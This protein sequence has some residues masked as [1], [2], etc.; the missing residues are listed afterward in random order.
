MVDSLRKI[1]EKERLVCDLQEI[2]I[3][4]GTKAINHSQFANDT[5]LIGGSLTMI[6]EKF[7]K[8]L[9]KFMITLGGKVNTGKSHIYRWN[10]SPLQMQSIDRILEFPCVLNWIVSKYLGMPITLVVLKLWIDSILLKS[11]K[12]KCSNGA[13]G[14]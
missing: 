5:L 9:N 12:I 6:T 1:L 7:K 3:L 13:I 11:S 2:I 14:G 8:V 4:K 10:T